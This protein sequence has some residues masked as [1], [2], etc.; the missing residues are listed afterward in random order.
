M[1]VNL[2]HES[3]TKISL[4]G[5]HN[6]TKLNAKIS[7]ICVYGFQDKSSYGFGRTLAYQRGALQ[8]SFQNFQNKVPNT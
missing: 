7:S 4:K 2:D 1:H 3:M 8:K 5:H 6:L